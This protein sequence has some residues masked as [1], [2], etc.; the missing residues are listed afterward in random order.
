M[1]S[2]D[3]YVSI[4]TGGASGIGRALTL[5]LARE[6]SNT[7]IADLNPEALE[8]TAHDA[9]SEDTDVIAIETDV[10]KVEDVKDMV[11]AGLEHFGK[12]DVVVSNAG[13]AGAPGWHEIPYSREDDWLATY[14]VNV[15]GVVNVTEA[16]AP[17]LKERRWGKIINIASVAGRAGRPSLPHYSAS[18]AAVIDYT[19]SSAMK[20][21]QFNINVNAICPG[22]LWTPMWEQ[23][24]ARYAQNDPNYTGLSAR[25]VFDRMVEANM[26]M[27]REQ[28]P[29]DVAELA[30]FLVSEGA[31]N[32]TGQAINVDGG[33]FFS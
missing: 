16:V 32:I 15:K 3:G 1:L 27:G 26:L 25:E 22:L 23:V 28:T 7:V 5:K 2:L 31:R 12:I 29:D 8:R 20:L 6:G 18:K 24:G 4:V 14:E 11:A 9:R 19:Y 10:T 33:F 17:V 13:V 21:G 30:A